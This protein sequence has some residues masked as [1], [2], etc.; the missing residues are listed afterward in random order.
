VFGSVH[1]KRNSHVRP[2]TR[3]GRRAETRLYRGERQALCQVPAC[4]HIILVICSGGRYETLSGRLPLLPSVFSRS[5]VQPGPEATRS[6]YDTKCAFSSSHGFA[7]HFSFERNHISFGQSGPIRWNASQRT[8]R[9]PDCVQ[10]T[11]KN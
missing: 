1:E 5:S 6:Q 3:S 9:D 7:Q 2:R 11:K 10:R 8:S 4:E